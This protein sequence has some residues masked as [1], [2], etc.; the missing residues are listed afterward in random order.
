MIKLFRK[1]PQKSFIHDLIY[2]LSL[3]KGDIVFNRETFSRCLLYRHNAAIGTYWNLFFL[4][5][6]L[7][8]SL[9][10]YQLDLCLDCRHID[11]NKMS[12]PSCCVNNLPSPGTQKNPLF[13]FQYFFWW[14]DYIIIIY[15]HWLIFHTT[16]HII[17][18]KI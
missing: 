18:S 16:V 2:Y 12:E 8:L 6:S 13:I 11:I 9:V 4:D 14:N 17:H 10:F 5:N 1:Y 7:Y 15:Q 3:I